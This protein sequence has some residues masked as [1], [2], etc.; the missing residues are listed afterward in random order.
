M[1][2]FGNCVKCLA[3]A[4]LWAAA[5]APAVA[6]PAAGTLSGTVVDESGGA[7]ADVQVVAESSPGT[8]RQTLSDAQGR[9]AITGLNPGRY[10]VTAQRSGFAPARMTDVVIAAAS[11]RT[12][13]IEMKIAPLNETVS[14]RV[15]PAEV[16]TTPSTIDVAPTEVRSVAGAGENIV[17]VDRDA[18]PRG[19]VLAESPACGRQAQQ[20]ELPVRG[21]RHGGDLGDQACEFVANRR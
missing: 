17:K 2:R 9:F 19:Q 14:V 11:E 4:L 8:G 16:R 6:Q 18:V 3:I 5:A 12:I 13:A 1:T 7:L 15:A 10:V 20:P 21:V